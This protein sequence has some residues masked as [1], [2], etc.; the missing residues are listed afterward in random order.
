MRLLPLQYLLLQYRYR[1]IRMLQI[2]L[3]VGRGTARESPDVRILYDRLV[4]VED[5]R[6]DKRQDPAVV[7]TRIPSRRRGQ[8]SRR[9]GPIKGH[10]VLLVRIHREVERRANRTQICLC[11]QP[12]V[13]RRIKVLPCYV[14]PGFLGIIADVGT[15]SLEGLAIDIDPRV[16]RR[17]RCF[18][19]DVR[20][21]VNAVEVDPL[22]VVA[23]PIVGRWRETGHRGKRR[24]GVDMR[25]HFVVLYAR[26]DV[27]RPPHDAWD[28]PAAFERGS[29]LTPEWCRAGIWIGI[30]PG[31]IVCGHYHDRI[32]CDGPDGIHDLSDVG[33]KLHQRVRVVSE[34]RPAR[35]VRR[36]IG[37]VVHL[38]VIDIHEERLVAVGV[39]LDVFDCV[40]CLLLVEGGK[41]LVGDLAEVFGGWPATPSH[42]FRF[43]FSL[44]ILANS[45]LYDGNQGWNHLFV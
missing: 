38:E 18:P 9:R 5:Y 32:G 45:G 7:L 13:L 10:V 30:Q 11:A 28:A 25:H 8:H 43:T 26:R 21:V 23:D 35:E 27:I 37:R 33:V 44:Y 39:L 16:A 22:A 42:S 12:R 6:L 40:V 15:C 34:M 20:T 29:F 31:A 24:P 3:H 36:R 2:R 14:H 4:E 17:V 41:S 1:V 19:Q